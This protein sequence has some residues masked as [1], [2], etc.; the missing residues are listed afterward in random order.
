MLKRAHRTH[1]FGSHLLSDICN[2]TW[3]TLTLKIMLFIVF[4]FFLL[5]FYFSFH[6]QS[7]EFCYVGPFGGLQSVKETKNWL[8][9]TI[10]C[11][12]PSKAIAKFRPLSK[13]VFFS[14]KKTKKENSCRPLSISHM[15]SWGK[16][17]PFRIF[18]SVM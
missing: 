5:F 8:P 2:W 9:K 13:L 18:Y 12:R 7:P 11:N 16:A 1:F 10:W 6:H 3:G 15:I 14:K 4:R 17:V